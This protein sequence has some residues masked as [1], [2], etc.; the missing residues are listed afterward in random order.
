METKG[1]KKDNTVFIFSIILAVV[2]A[3]WAVILSQNF[4]EVSNVAFAFLTNDFAW[5]YL[6]D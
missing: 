1:I 5:L 3:G 4:S 6:F 2:V